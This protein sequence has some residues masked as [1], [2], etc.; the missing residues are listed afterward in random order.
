MNDQ[1]ATPN[2]QDLEIDLDG[3]ER[4]HAAGAVVLDVRNPDEYEDGHVPGAALIPLGELE[5]RLDEVPV[6]DPLYVICAAGGRSLR[7]AKFL[8]ASGRQAISVA[9]GT[10]GWIAQGN[11]VVSGADPR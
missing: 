1:D 11:P 7:A 8:A 5:D 3:F 4:A 9:G 10:K 2:E 6:A